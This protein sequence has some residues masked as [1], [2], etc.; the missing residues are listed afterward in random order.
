[1]SGATTVIA[2]LAP[3]VVAIALLTVIVAI[4]KRYLASM[5]MPAGWV[6][7]PRI[8]RGLWRV[9]MR[10]IIGMWRAGRALAWLAQGRRK[11]RRIPSRISIGG[12]PRAR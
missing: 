6:S 1:M 7:I 11:V 4:A 12:A 2:T 5:G 9:T 10:T 3:L 8:V